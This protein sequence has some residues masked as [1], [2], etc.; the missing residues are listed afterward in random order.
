MALT[1][2]FTAVQPYG[3]PS[4]ITFTDTSTGSDVNV[5]SRK[6]YVKKAD[7][8]YIVEEG[9]PNNYITWAIADAA[10]TL[11]LLTEDVATEITIQWVK[12]SS[13]GYS[14]VQ[15]ISFTQF[16]EIFDYG[17]TQ[18]LAANPLL[19]NDN[20]FFPHKANL[21]ISIDSGNQ[22]M[23]LA[24]DLYAAQQCYDRAT[25]LRLSSQYYFNINS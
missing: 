20:D 7:G 21:R 18:M 13:V 1:Q 3:N 8:S 6:I 9:N 24:G 10:I 15:K 4:N 23:I 19:I 11:E 16:N 12:I 14:Q 17:L 5:I 2:S 25:A 22:A